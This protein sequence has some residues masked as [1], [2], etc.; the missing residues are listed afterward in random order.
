MIIHLGWRSDERQ[1]AIGSVN[2]ILIWWDKMDP[3]DGLA[4]RT[5]L[6]RDQSR[7]AAAS[8]ETH[9]GRLCSVSNEQRSEVSRSNETATYYG[10]LFVR[11]TARRRENDG[12]REKKKVG[13]TK[14]ETGDVTYTRCGLA[15]AVVPTAQ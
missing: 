3:R 10:D 9:Y 2:L 6:W 15:A 8:N 1:R 7:D 13:W 5:Y 14:R 4:R 12:E 11:S